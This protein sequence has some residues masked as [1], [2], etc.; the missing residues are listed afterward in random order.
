[1]F[2]SSRYAI[3]L[4]GIGLS[5]LM[6]GLGYYM[7]LSAP[8]PV[9]MVDQY[10]VLAWNDLG[11][12]C[13]NRDFRD[14]AVLPPF[15]TLWAQVIKVGDPPQILTTGITV[16]YFFEDN[17]YSVGKSNFWT[18]DVGLFGV[19]L[20][21]NVGLKGKGLAGQM[22]AQSDHF[23]AEGIPLTEFRDSAPSIAYPY[24]L[25]TIVVRDSLSS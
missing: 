24:Q 4:R 16:N 21:D 25:A 13:Y 6:A 14:L 7:A 9:T 23:I 11:M 3:S 15:N 10:K 20:P 5:F 17:T 12:H 1:M 2:R 8:S 19:D 18:Y 22:D